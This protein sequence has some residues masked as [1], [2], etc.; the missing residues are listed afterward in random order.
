MKRSRL[1]FTLLIVLVAGLLLVGCAAKQQE[2][3]RIAQEEEAARQAAQARADSIAQV[4]KA[5]AD[6]LAAVEAEEQRRLEA[7]RQEAARK[8]AEE[9]AAKDALQIVYFAFDQS[10]LTTDSR[11]TLQENAELLR[12][13]PGWQVLVEGHCDERGSTE[14]NLALGERRAATVRQYYVDYGIEADRIRMTSYGEERPAVEGHNE[15]A[16][17]QN[18]RAVTVVQ[19]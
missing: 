1:V 13:Y 15:K 2:A 8:A 16:W 3:E 6:S 19:E 18:R 10:G 5:R 4:E 17:S 14:Y 11:N 7:E 12:R 9:T